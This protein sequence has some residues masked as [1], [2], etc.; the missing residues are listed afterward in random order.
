MFIDTLAVLDR[1]TGHRVAFVLIG[2]ECERPETSSRVEKATRAQ[3]KKRKKKNRRSPKCVS[4]PDARPEFSSILLLFFPLTN[5][6]RETYA[7]PNKR[8]YGFSGHFIMR[9]RRRYR[10]IVYRSPAALTIEF[11]AFTNEFARVFVV[12]D[13]YLFCSR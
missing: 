12:L 10:Y 11:Y 5:S 7:V 9:R 3:K 4:L 1:R 2:V 6:S 13:V 8:E